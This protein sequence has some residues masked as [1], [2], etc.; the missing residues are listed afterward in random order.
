MST[1][2]NKAIAR[3]WFEEGINRHNLAIMDELF[4]PD[5]TEHMPIGPGAQSLEEAKQFVAGT[6]AGMPDMRA[7]VEEMVAEG[8]KVVVR[9]TVTGTQTGDFM[10][11]PATGKPIKMTAID[12]LR[13]KDG[14][15][16][17][18]W[19]EGD[20]LGMMQQLGVIPTPGQAPR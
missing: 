12:I 19:L 11:I 10:G 3:R 15:I 16:A 13:F 6:S 14:K 2:E 1:E 9:Y 20:Q 5:F 18:H 8:D 4:A 17:E 7:T